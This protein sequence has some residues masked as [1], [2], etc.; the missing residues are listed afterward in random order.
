MVSKWLRNASPVLA[1][2][3]A[4]LH[5]IDARL[6]R[7]SISLREA[8]KLSKPEADVLLRAH[9]QEAESGWSA[10]TLQ[11]VIDPCEAELNACRADVVCP[12]CTYEY[13]PVGKLPVN[14][15]CD[16]VLAFYAKAFPAECDITV[17]GVFRDLIVCTAEHECDAHPVTAA[18]TTAPAA[19][20]D[21][22]P[23]STAA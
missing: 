8:Q 4:T 18:P 3:A 7:G 16:A 10:R 12:M 6:L 17:E 9:E 1:V 19:A 13:V 23:P 2:I 5:R 22:A 21:T 11:A 15:T 14:G 20:G